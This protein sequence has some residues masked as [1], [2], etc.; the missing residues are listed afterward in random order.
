MWESLSYTYIYL[1]PQA[2]AWFAEH[3][4]GPPA[5]AV[6]VGTTPL[7]RFFSADRQKVALVF[8]PQGNEGKGL[9]DEQQVL[10]AREALRNIQGEA[11]L[12]IVISPWGMYAER[13]LAA[14]IDGMAQILL[15]GGSGVGFPGQAGTATPGLLWSR[16]ESKGYAV[17]VITVMQWPASG[18]TSP[19]IDGVNFTAESIALGQSIPDNAAILTH[20]RPI[21]HDIP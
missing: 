17:T 14:D 11:A 20:I 12:T 5:Q 18:T 16:P 4:G 2:Q 10:A 21:A 19:W 15:G 9:P 7:I 6:S 1:S 13:K 8:L 3:T